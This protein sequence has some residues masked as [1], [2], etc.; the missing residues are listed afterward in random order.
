MKYFSKFL[1]IVSRPSNPSCLRCSNRCFELSPFESGVLGYV[2][3][4]PVDCVFWEEWSCQMKR[5]LV[6]R[7]TCSQLRTVR[8]DRPRF[9]FVFLGLRNSRFLGF[10]RPALLVRC[11]SK[12]RV[13]ALLLRI[14]PDDCQV[15]MLF[16]L[17]LED[18]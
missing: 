1:L 7:I 6:Y 5:L 15:T 17:W 8:P 13:R 2:H 16:L 10:T 14:L 9:F 11:T 18:D 3:S 4:G 12:Y